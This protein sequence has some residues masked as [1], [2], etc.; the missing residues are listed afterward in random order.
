MR[1]TK[2]VEASTNLLFDLERDI[3]NALK[4]AFSSGDIP[5]AILGDPLDG[6]YDYPAS[7]RHTEDNVDQ[8]RFAEGCLDALWEELESSVKKRTSLSVNKIIKNRLL[9]PRELHRTPEWMP[10]LVA[11]KAALVLKDRDPNI[12]HFGTAPSVKDVITPA[13]PKTK[14]K[15]RGARGTTEDSDD[16]TSSPEA[17]DPR[18]AEITRTIKVPKRAYKVLSA[19]FPSAGADSHQR[20]EIAW[21]ELLQAMNT[22]GLQP[23]KLYGSVWMFMPKASDECKVEMK[24]SIQFHEPKEVRRGSKIPPNMVRTFG[25]RLKQAYGWEDGMFVCE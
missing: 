18:V 20:M 22:I 2:A 13:K 9:E 23:E 1:H 15:T 10:P 21:E 6:K 14:I 8:M 19:L 5:S 17:P 3:R 12:S 4:D 25:R 24:R 11:P 7:K 16:K